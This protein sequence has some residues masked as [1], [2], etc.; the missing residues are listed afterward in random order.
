VK[1]GRAAWE[2]CFT[3]AARSAIFGL[4][5]SVSTEQRETYRSLMDESSEPLRQFGLWRGPN[6]VFW[7]S[8]RFVKVS[9]NIIEIH[10][11]STGP[12]A[13]KYPGYN[14][15]RYVTEVVLKQ[16]TDGREFAVLNTHLVPNGPRVAAVWRTWA[17]RRSL[18]VL[19][20]LVAKHVAAGRSVILMGDM[21]IKEPFAIARPFRWYRGEG[22]DKIGGTLSGAAKTFPAPT[23]HKRGVVATVVIPKEK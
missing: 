11:P 19:R 1:V 14:E 2:Q 17:R 21:N 22:I 5:E 10:G 16:K 4:N 8:E 13:S 12:L 18:K 6:P 20:Q 9:G 15:A 7:R 3:L 23:D